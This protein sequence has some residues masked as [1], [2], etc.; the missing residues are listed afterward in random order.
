VA[1]EGE[2]GARSNQSVEAAGKAFEKY[3]QRG[4]ELDAREDEVEQL[5][6]EL[7]RLGST[8]DEEEGGKKMIEDQPTADEDAVREDASC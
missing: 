5:R 2:S 6:E 4:R 8:L 7:R 1:T 3:V